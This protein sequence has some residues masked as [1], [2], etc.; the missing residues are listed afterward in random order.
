MKKILKISLIITVLLCFSI[1]VSAGGN[2]SNI[3]A[4]EQDYVLLATVV[5]VNDSFVV[6]APYHN[7]YNGENSQQLSVSNNISI[8]KFRYSY[9]SDHADIS[10]TPRVG[11][12]IFVSLNKNGSEYVV[13]NGVYKTSS[14]DYK[15]LTFYASESMKGRDCMSEIVALAYFVRTDGSMRS[16]NFENGELTVESD[17]KILTLYPTDNIN[18]TVTFVNIQGK[19]ID[20]VKTKDVIT[21]GSSH[22]ESKPDFRWLFSVALIALSALTGAIVIYNVNNKEGKSAK[23]KEGE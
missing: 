22:E 5:D 4:G 14:V 18:D 1:N 12:N 20:N 13:A 10:T 15:L 6:V 8:A 11:D 3:L 21:E 17:S 16:F 9:C 2:V 7:I 19:V 23:T